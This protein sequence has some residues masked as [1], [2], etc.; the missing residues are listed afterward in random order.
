MTY[1]AYLTRK[2]QDETITETTYCGVR[3]YRVRPPRGWGVSGA[4]DQEEVVGYTNFS[5]FLAERTPTDVA[6]EDFYG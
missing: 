6:K 3:V 2:I 1:N 5:G 4:E